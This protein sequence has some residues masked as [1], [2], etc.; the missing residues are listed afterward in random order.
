MLVASVAM[1]LAGC[2]SGGRRP[3]PEVKPEEAAFAG[4][5]A[6]ERPFVVLPLHG[7]PLVAARDP[8]V[9][10]R[11][12]WADLVRTGDAGAGRE[13]AEELLASDPGFHP[14]R[15]LAAQ[16]DFLA[17]D[18][19]AA[20]ERLGPVL[21][22]LPAYTAAQ[23]L[24]GR[25]AERS[26]RIPEAFGAYQAAAEVSPPAAQR[27]A[28]LR[29]RAIEIVGNRLT[30]ALARGRIEDAAAALARLERWAPEDGATLEGARA[31]AAAR[32]DLRAELTAV[33]RLLARAPDRRDLLIRR[34]ELELEVG[35]ASEGLQILQR[36]AAEQPGDRVLQEKLEQAK[37]RW[38]VGLLPANV[39]ELSRRG[40]L[41]RG[42]FAA[43]VYRLVPHVRTARSPAGR[44][45]GDILE[46]PWREEIARV[47][48][49][50]LMD[51]DPTLHSFSPERSVRRSTA[52]LTLLRAV[53]TLGPPAA[54]L[55]S[56]LGRSPAQESVCSAAARCGLVSEPADCLPGAT[57]SGAEALELVRRALRL[58]SAS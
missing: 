56:P 36:L 34:A 44:I 2:P 12:A 7:Y 25:A 55:A 15:V 43:L 46:H 27:A 5:P 23:L 17:G 33:G 41:T 22:E 51:V 16:A 38:R 21:E 3:V 50:G 30:D 10:V 37:F 35:D 54:C 28:A 31:L 6:A 13:A 18:D 1:A 42:D 19:A 9:R 20:L 26:G 32:G 48:N 24:R 52:L 57:L 11:E 14:A 4:V 47:V 8:A 29:G 49:L 45:A 40:E 53:E 58:F 39:Q